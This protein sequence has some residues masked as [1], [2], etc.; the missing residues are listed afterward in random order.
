MARSG[1]LE[2][3]DRASE[4]VPKY[5]KPRGAAKM[6]AVVHLFPTLRSDAYHIL[7]TEWGAWM[8]IETGVDD[9]GGI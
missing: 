2:F 4:T 7:N 8:L 1:R 3:N 6:A 9:D 5:R